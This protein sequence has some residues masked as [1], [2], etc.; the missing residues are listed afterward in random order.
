MNEILTAF[1]SGLVMT[2]TGILGDAE[3]M[4]KIEHFHT[5]TTS[6]CFIPLTVTVVLVLVTA[7]LS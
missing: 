4:E 7:V 2:L 6:D 5:C 3:P 1:V